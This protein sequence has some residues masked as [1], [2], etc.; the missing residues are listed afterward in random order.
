MSVNLTPYAPPYFLTPS[1]TGK[2]AP[3]ST[4]ELTSLKKMNNP[5]YLGRVIAEDF[6][7]DSLFAEL[8]A[9]GSE[10]T[11]ATDQVI[12]EEQDADFNPTIVSGTGA[13]SFATATGTFTIN[14]AA[15]PV[16]PFDINSQRPTDAKW[17][18]VKVGMQFVA[19][20]T[21]GKKANG[22]ITSIAAD[23]KSFVASP[24]GGNWNGLGAT[25]ITVMFT[26]NNLDH[27]ELAPCI[28]FTGYAP[29]YENTM[30]KDSECVTYC[31]E[32]EIA[33]SPD[34][35]DAQ[36]LTK[37]GDEYYN[38][39]ERLNDAQKVLTLRSENAFAFEKKLTKTEA[40]G[41]QLGTNGLFTILENRATKHLGMIT[42]K[43]D[44][45]NLA[46]NLKSKGIKQATL[47]VSSE[48]Y[49]KLIE[50]LDDTK[51]Q[52]TPF[53]DNTNALYHIGFAG[54]RIGETEIRFKSWRVLDQYSNVGKRYH[55]LLIP[56]GKLRVKFNGRVTSAN[57]LNIGWF[58]K[59]GDVYK[60]KRSEKENPNGDGNRTIHYKNKFVPI[61][62]MPNKFMMG[63]TV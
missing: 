31:E 42:N 46:A 49:T 51:I 56:I 63:L 20:D 4:L 21:A 38:L 15:I 1:D 33:N 62:L 2:Q 24:I 39:D 34:G 48:Q 43:Q 40:N 28:G 11:F 9:M 12:W 19:F 53:T 13:V 23:K 36:P 18:Q 26:G 29:A 14:N 10:Y 61:V 30:F 8:M 60:Y 37:I 3:I 50:I 47:R 58:G 16:D 35:V 7:D 45:M 54:F 22:K 25:N 44:L 55:W 57:Y 32:T 17:L 41:G 27:C 5:K 6:F 52:Y 59:Q